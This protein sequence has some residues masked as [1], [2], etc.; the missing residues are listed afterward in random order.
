MLDLFEIGYTFCW[1]LS[2]RWLIDRLV[3]QDGTLFIFYFFCVAW[4][5]FYRWGGNFV[6]FRSA[7]LFLVPHID[8]SL[9][10]SF[11]DTCRLFLIPWRHI[12]YL[13]SCGL[14]LPVCRLRMPCVLRRDWFGWQQ[15]LSFKQQGNLNNFERWVTRL[16]IMI[17]FVHNSYFITQKNGLSCSIII[18]I[19]KKL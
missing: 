15:I 4:R 18:R 9:C 2:L 12:P 5:L 11:P 17:L 8:L 3:D 16:G 13:S 10:G 14:A 19:F 7:V 6:H 1:S